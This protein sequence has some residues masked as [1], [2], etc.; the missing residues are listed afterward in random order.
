[1]VQLSGKYQRLPPLK[2]YTSNFFTFACLCPTNLW[3]AKHLVWPIYGDC[4]ISM[5]IAAYNDALADFKY[6][7]DC[8]PL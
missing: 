6:Q 8:S 4:V 1:M 7:T 5:Q 3:S 2:E